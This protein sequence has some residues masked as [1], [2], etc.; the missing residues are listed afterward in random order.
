MIATVLSAR[1]IMLPRRLVCEFTITCAT[2]NSTFKKGTLVFSSMTLY[3]PRR[4]SFELSPPLASFCK[5][6]RTL[7]DTS[8]TGFLSKH[9]KLAEDIKYLGD[10]IAN[11]IYSGV[12]LSRFTVPTLASMVV[13][14]RT[15][16]EEL[17]KDSAGQKDDF[18][19]KEMVAYDTRLRNYEELIREAG[20]RLEPWSEHTLSLFRAIKEK[21]SGHGLIIIGNYDRMASKDAR[22]EVYKGVLQ[23]RENAWQ[24]GWDV[25]FNIRTQASITSENEHR[26]ALYHKL[27]QEA[28]GTA[29]P[30]LPM[31]I[32]S[33]KIEGTLETPAKNVFEGLMP[34]I[35]KL[36]EHEALET[37]ARK[38]F[39]G[40]LDEIFK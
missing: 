9:P 27:K 6:E 38:H 34:N 28:G 14:R 22:N 12:N 40:R 31:E 24:L 11:P 21:D 30:G 17:K 23:N 18:T 39:Q 7:F 20:Q 26:T 13:E 2:L 19:K 5:S 16:I 15:R 33:V 4:Q 29:I 32:V 37:I 36:E 25:L 8:L 10:F 3:T 35:A 1:M